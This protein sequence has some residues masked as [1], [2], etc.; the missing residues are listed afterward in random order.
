MGEGETNPQEVHVLLG[1]AVEEEE[2]HD[3][4]AE[5]AQGQRP[6]PPRRQHPLAGLRDRLSDCR[7]TTLHQK[8]G[9]VL[10]KCSCFAEKY[11]SKKKTIA[12]HKISAKPQ[13]LEDARG[14]ENC[15]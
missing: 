2:R 4:E 6:E 5:G 14:C 15:Q 9:P 8:L 10:K 13:Q 7:S 12:R 11:P 3:E 1:I